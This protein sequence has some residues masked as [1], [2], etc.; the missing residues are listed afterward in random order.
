MARRYYPLSIHLLTVHVQDEAQMKLSEE[1]YPNVNSAPAT[2]SFG[3]IGRNVL[4]L[5]SMMPI[6]SASHLRIT[7][8]KKASERLVECKERRRRTVN[9]NL[10]VEQY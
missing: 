8:G 5:N 2:P 6:Y 9:M 10:T 7:V 3:M 4:A 1:I